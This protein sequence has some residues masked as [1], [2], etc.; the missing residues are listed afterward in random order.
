MTTGQQSAQW[1]DQ[2]ERPGKPQETP[3]H[4]PKPNSDQKKVTVTVCWSAK[5]MIHTAS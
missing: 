4:F 1:M 3:K 5:D 2:E